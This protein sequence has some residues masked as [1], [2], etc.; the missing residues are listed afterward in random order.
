MTGIWHLSQNN[1]FAT[2]RISVQTAQVFNEDYPQTATV[3]PSSCPS[4]V[5]S[6]RI[7]YYTLDHIY[8][9]TESSRLGR[10]PLLSL[11]DRSIAICLVYIAGWPCEAAIVRTGSRKEPSP[12]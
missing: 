10:P 5:H 8:C 12:V 3:M 11:V 1:L 4:Q 7:L 2:S 6:S 9:R